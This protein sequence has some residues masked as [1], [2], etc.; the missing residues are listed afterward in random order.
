MNWF[1][2]LSERE[3]LRC[4]ILREFVLK[5]SVRVHSKKVDELLVE[6]EEKKEKYLNFFLAVQ[7]LKDREVEELSE[8]DYYSDN[9]TLSPSSF[10]QLIKTGIPIDFN[11]HFLN[12]EIN[13]IGITCRALP[14]LIEELK[15]RNSFRF[16]HSRK[17]VS[18][19]KD[20]KKELS[21]QKKKTLEHH[22]KKNHFSEWTRLFNKQ[23]SED[24]AFF[25]KKG[26]KREEISKLLLNKLEAHE[27]A[28]LPRWF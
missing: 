4:D 9:I 7:T 20:F 15:K 22:A 17:K 28:R 10:R 24:I 11:N 14:S 8:M 27:H 1:K 25:E 21:L 3:K 13:G 26:L 16:K 12:A 2:N 19:L 5:K 18:T 23:L 6:L